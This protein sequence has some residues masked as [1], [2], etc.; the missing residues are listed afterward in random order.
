MKEVIILIYGLVRELEKSLKNLKDKLLYDNK[1]YNF[2]FIIN[3]QPSKNE[4]ELECTNK[5]K[6]ILEKETLLDIILYY[7]PN[8][9]G[10]KILDANYIIMKR[11]QHSLKKLK[12]HNKYDIFINVRTDISI[13]SDTKINLDEYI[14]TDLFTIIPGKL[15]RPCIFHNRDWD[16]LWIGSNKSFFIWFYSYIYGV[17][18]VK[19]YINDTD[20]KKNNS[21]NLILN[22][23]LTEYQ[24]KKIINKYNL[25]EQKNDK[26]YWATRDFERYNNMYHKCIKNLE[27]HNCSFNMS[28]NFFSCII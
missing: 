2:N 22:Y 28:N 6:K 26:C 16:F 27:D 10:D 9:K 7:L 19:D 25:I 4:T 14:T 3:T 15:T 1:K 5:I 12:N 8:Q 18:L 11:L 17:S 21:L 23:D 24:K 13:I 20:L